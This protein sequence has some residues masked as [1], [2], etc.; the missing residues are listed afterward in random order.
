[1]HCASA[2]NVILKSQE[3]FLFCSV[4]ICRQLRYLLKIISKNSLNVIG[5]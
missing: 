5:S 1:M 4:F 2:F 3:R